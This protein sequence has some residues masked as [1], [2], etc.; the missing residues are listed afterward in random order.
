MFLSRSNLSGVPAY[1]N[2]PGMNSQQYNENEWIGLPV[3]ERLHTDAGRLAQ[4]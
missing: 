3:K 2:I 1:F 4:L